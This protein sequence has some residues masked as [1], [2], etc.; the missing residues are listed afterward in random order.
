MIGFIKKKKNEKSVRTLLLVYI[1]E[2]NVT[3]IRTVKFAG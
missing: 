3:T 2:R 1:C